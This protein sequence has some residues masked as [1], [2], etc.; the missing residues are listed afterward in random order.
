VYNRTITVTEANEGLDGETFFLYIF[1][2]AG[3]V[4]ALVGGQQALAT[5]AKKRSPR[6]ANRHIETGTG[7]VNVD[8]DWLPKE[9]LNQI[10]K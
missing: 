7:N 2:G 6:S 1:L 9:L 4:L 5:L 8:Y 3:L 10:S